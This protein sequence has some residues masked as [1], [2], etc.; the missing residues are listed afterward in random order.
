MRL[1][2]WTH[3]RGSEQVEMII[4][5]GNSSLTM[6]MLKIKPLHKHFFILFIYRTN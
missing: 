6:L 2:S 5:N 3:R 1:I 4:L